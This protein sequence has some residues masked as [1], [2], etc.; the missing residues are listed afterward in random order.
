M[1]LIFCGIVTI[2]VYK[3]VDPKGSDDSG[4]NVPDEV[5]N[6]LAGARRLLLL[7]GAV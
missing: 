1:C 5:V 4:L 7:S 3:F 6:P 2:I